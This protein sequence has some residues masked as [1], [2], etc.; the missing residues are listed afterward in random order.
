MIYG[1]DR[2]RAQ[3][4][5]LLDDA[6]AGHGSLVLISGEA[7]IGKTTLVDDLIHEARDRNCLVLTGGCYDLTTTPPYGPWIEV[8]RDYRPAE[9]YPNLP[10]WFG[11]PEEVGRVGSQARL[12]EET[13]VFFASVAEK[14]PLMIVL[15]DLHWSD[16]ASLDALRY[17][18]RQFSDISVMLAATYRDDEITRRHQLSRMLPAIVRESSAARLH[19]SALDDTAVHGLIGDRYD[20]SPEDLE[21]LS[22]H[23]S[24]LAEGNP[25]YVI[26]LLQTLEDVGSLSVEG[27]H[28]EVGALDR[29]VVPPLVS[30]LIEERLEF[31]DSDAAGLL[32]IAAI[33][34]Q[35]FGY[36]LWSAVSDADDDVLL[37]SLESALHRRLIEETDRSGRYR[38]THA[39]IREALYEREI[40][41]RRRQQ[42]RRIGDLLEA[43]SQPDPD[44]IAH[45]FQQAGDHRAIEWL[46][47]AADSA[48]R[49]F[50]LLTAAER[51][52]EALATLIAKD[53][54]TDYERGWLYYRIAA[55]LRVDNRPKS[56]AYLAEAERIATRSGDRLL[57]AY[58]KFMQGI[59]KG[60]AGDPV[61]A[62]SG[63]EEGV[64]RLAKIT[65]EDLGSVSSIATTLYG[66]ERLLT[67]THHPRSVD[68][69]TPLFPVNPAQGTLA[70]WQAGAGYFDKAVQNGLA[71]RDALTCVQA[72]SVGTLHSAGDAEYGLGKS[73]AAL[74]MPHDARNA[75]QRAIAIFTEIHHFVLIAG[76]YRCLLLDVCLPYETEDIDE[77]KRLACEDETAARMIGGR[78]R[79]HSPVL[80]TDNTTAGNWRRIRSLA[81]EELADP[82]TEATRRR[83]FQTLATIAERQGEADEAWAYIEEAFPPGSPTKPGTDDFYYQLDMALLAS[84]LSLARDEFPSARSWL[85]R[86]ASWLDWSGAVLGLA[87]A[88][89]GWATYYRLIDDCDLARE[90]AERAYDHASDPRQPLALIAADRFLGQL[91]VD[92]G[93]YDE[94]EER[95]VASLEL[96]EHCEAPFKVALTL[97][98]MAERAAKLGEV[99]EARGLIATVREICEPLGAKPTLE[100]VDE[101]EATL[102]TVRQTARQYPAGLTGREVEVLRLVARG[103]TDAEAAEELFISPRTVS[104]HLRSVYNKLG[105]NNRAEAAVRAVE[106][107]VV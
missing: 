103:M 37:E 87:E 30:Q 60:F 40:W 99:E 23:V 102:P 22:G 106:L 97:V 90:H 36:E 4:R 3:L 44:T 73:Y 89:L 65:Y 93:K 18:T 21:R 100:R 32:E 45:H 78:F 56:S 10:V 83:L 39:L 68:S 67:S 79:S 49:S 71:V 72:K 12:F 95:L 61:Q 64:N 38:F 34:G 28:A 17:L 20:L 85:E 96:A 63:M 82:L 41:P 31:L 5:E 80:W 88:Q 94:A 98:V 107:G 13:R 91:D 24:D 50:A 16:T 75:F 15:E 54:G 19:L 48:H 57:L 66:E 25:L 74:G 81:L 59:V 14:Q 53:I 105:V 11:N 1:R 47:R 70:M 8:L 62:L 35:E 77:R 42:H 29:V 51:C 2:E 52:D 46:I 104:Q 33:I 7:G 6:I 101:I 43:H 69:G 9:D 84:K 76:S 27:H 55:M 58:C 26:E 86:H 92:K